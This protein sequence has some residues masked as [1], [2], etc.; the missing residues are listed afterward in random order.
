MLA[1]R[2]RAWPTFHTVT[3]LRA[4]FDVGYCANDFQICPE[5][6]KVLQVQ[7]TYLDVR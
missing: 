4:G 5:Q 2:A 3:L 1:P 7:S 6:K